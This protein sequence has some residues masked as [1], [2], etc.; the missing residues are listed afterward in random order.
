MGRRV[1][2]SQRLQ[3]LVVSKRHLIEGKLGGIQLKPYSG[4]MQSLPLLMRWW[5]IALVG[6]MVWPGG[7]MAQAFSADYALGRFAADAASDARHGSLI[8]IAGV[9][10]TPVVHSDGR[11]AGGGLSVAAGKNW[12]AELA[13]GRSLQPNLDPAG[14]A[15]QQ[16]LRVAGGYRWADGRSL[17]L[18]LTGARG[19]S[20][21][22]L[23]L[24]YDW[25]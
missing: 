4:F 23:S 8:S 6:M 2:P 19:G 7:A 14:T 21:L 3:P 22:G 16:A 11:F 1:A 24:S 5:A 18:Q 12:F 25:P 20:R 15:V 10:L 17:S 13:A 9:R